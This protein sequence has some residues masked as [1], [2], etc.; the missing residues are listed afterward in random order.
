MITPAGQFDETHVAFKHHGLR[1]GRDAGQAEP[2]GKLAFVH[3][4]F[5]DKIGIFGVMNNQR[6][7]IA[8]VNKCAAHHQRIGDAVAGIG[9]G[10][11]ARGLQQAD[12]GHL[13]AGEALGQGCHRMNVDDGRVRGPAQH[14]IDGRGVVDR[15]RGVRLTDDGGDAAR[16]RRLACR[17][18]GLAMARARF[19]DEGAH[20]DEAGATTLPPQLM[21]SVPSGTPAAPMPR[22]ASRITPSA[23]STSP[24]PSRSRDGRSAGVG[25]QDRA[26]AV[27]H[28]VTLRA[29]EGNQADDCL[30][31]NQNCN[32][33]KHDC[34]HTG[35]VAFRIKEVDR[36]DCGKA[37]NQE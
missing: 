14:E 22:R 21:I 8:R 26:E 31:H 27:Q 10:D 15:G 30:R 11:G 23:I 37:A 29:K 35:R 17:S 3:D 24:G 20:I 5:A 32:A 16:G 4:A 13:L 28:A 36:G 1:R 6:V 2:C 34:D 18:E 25:E 7:E 9:E 12:F 19:A 33:G